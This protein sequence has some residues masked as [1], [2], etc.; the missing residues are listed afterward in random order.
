[1]SLWQ[2]VGSIV[3]HNVVVYKLLRLWHVMQRQKR[4]AADQPER[5]AR[6]GRELFEARYAR[7]L[8]MG[9]ESIAAWRQRER[10]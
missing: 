3:I 6:L 7:D 10:P 4:Y 2:V 1:M 8:A 9:H 5:I